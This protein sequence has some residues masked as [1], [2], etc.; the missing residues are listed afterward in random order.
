MME[1]A[2]LS[3]APA[4]GLLAAYPRRTWGAV[5]VAVAAGLGSIAACLLCGPGERR[6][7]AA[8]GLWSVAGALYAIHLCRREVQDCGHVH[9]KVRQLK[10]RRVETAKAAAEARA[11][12]EETQRSHKESAALYAMVKG[13]SA[14][15]SWEEIKPRLETA[16][17]QYLGV[18]DFALYVAGRPPRSTWRVDRGGSRAEDDFQPLASRNLASS[19]GGAWVTLGRRLQEAAL[20]P[21]QAHVLDRPERALCVPVIDNAELLGV[22]Y[23]RLPDAAD[24]RALLAKASAF[25]GEVAFAF[26]RVKLFQEMERL[27]EIDGVT[28]VHRRGAFDERLGEEVVRARTFKTTFCL[29][30]LDIDHF[31]SLN[32]RYGHPFGDQVLRR[33]GEILNHSFYETDFVARYGG[34]EF[35]VILPRAQ[36]DGARRKAEA[37]RNAIEFESF[38]IALETVR[39]TVSIG[40][41]HFPRDAAAPEEL[42]SQADL[43]LYRAKSLG[44]NRVVEFTG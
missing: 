21:W 36:Y 38:P 5:A 14:A 20:S 16:V 25:A 9:E 17:D 26:R 4:A 18:A 43:A 3:L 11:Q 7:A 31:K 23:V 6:L 12:G 24:P 41:A 33:I 22:F 32:D 2:L 34:E 37:V 40:L 39:V 30:L 10:V 1:L 35:G 29:M 28:G 8:V 15:L 42:F 44:R 19:P 27:S 13:L